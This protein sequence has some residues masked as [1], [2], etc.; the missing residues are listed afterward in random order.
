MADNN[1]QRPFRNADL[2]GRAMPTAGDPSAGGNDPL[3]E[4]ARL[5]GQ[6][7]PFGDAGREN[8]RPAAAPQAEPMVRGLAAQGLPR[9]PYPQQAPAAPPPLND[10]ARQPSRDD[11][12]R[13]PP[14]NDFARQPAANDFGRQ[15]AASDFGRQPSAN[16]FGRQ[17]SLEDLARQPYGSP[18]LPGRDEFYQA[19]APVPGYDDRAPAM[20]GYDDGGYDPNGPL[21]GEDQDFYDDAPPPRR[22]MGVLAIGAVFALAV[23]GT[24]GAFGYRT[25]FGS[26]S[27]G[28][29]PV[30]KA[31]TKPVKIVPDKDTAQQTKL[32]NDR[33]GDR[34]GDQKM[35]SREEQ[36]VDLN[37]DKPAGVL[38]P[39]P[40]VAAGG[41][42]Q[43]PA[44]MP[45]NGVVGGDP[46]KIHTITIR[47][48]Q[49][50][51]PNTGSAPPQADVANVMPPDQ[52]Q[53][54]VANGMPPNQPQ[55]NV[56]NGMPPDQPAMPPAPAMPEPQIAAP[57]PQI[58]APEPAP[59]PT[60]THRP[61]PAPNRVATAADNNA[62]L[63]LTPDSVTSMRTASTSPA[64]A[65]A[66][67]RP[68]TTAAAAGGGYAVQVSSRRNKADAESALSRMKRKYANVIGDHD[69]M[70]RRV[71][72]GAKGVY[73][74]AMVGP[75][76]S[77]DE[78]SK[79][80]KELKAA[81]GSCFVQRI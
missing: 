75:F 41:A 29:P 43:T 46:K 67:T 62:P 63:S 33:V 12:A 7:D 80:C 68:A 54:D 65:P 70:V 76:G 22:R 32:I 10:L 47:P 6:N 18:P 35:V 23:I 48:D 39:Q 73:Y 20:G 40:P 42:M 61:A 64:P 69:V 3:A 57:E 49:G 19:Q 26:V 56:A 27:S 28:P 77:S 30:I 14:A 2:Q 15:A 52:P 78:A 45:G 31:D 79:M 51:T 16:D 13:Q 74:R 34:V 9:D 1:P 37:Q 8:P 36:P 44:P 21:Y 55:A 72:L 25:L 11:F 59:R 5:I 17:P 81:G 50:G 60:M 53:A 38:G 58:A 4:L 71:D 24:A 66:P